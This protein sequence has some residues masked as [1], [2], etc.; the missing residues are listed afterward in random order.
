MSLQRQKFWA[1]EEKLKTLEKSEISIY[2]L[3]RE[4]DRFV[5]CM[6][7]IDFTDDFV[8]KIELVRKSESSIKTIFNI[9]FSEMNPELNS[10][11]KEESERSNN[12]NSLLLRLEALIKSI[13]DARSILTTS[14]KNKIDIETNVLTNNTNIA[15]F[16]STLSSIFN[17]LVYHSIKRASEIL[18]KIKEPVI[19][20]SEK[21]DKEVVIKEK[22]KIGFKM[23]GDGRKTLFNYLIYAYFLRTSQSAVPIFSNLRPSESTIKILPPEAMEYRRMTATPIQTHTPVHAGSNSGSGEKEGLS[24]EELYD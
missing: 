20:F 14:L 2:E 18:I 15:F 13:G 8:G 10:L 21:V 19:V 12:Y 4:V 16:V 11:I 22:E 5:T 1:I 7:A 9:T 17:D 24:E 23:E 6:N 3:C